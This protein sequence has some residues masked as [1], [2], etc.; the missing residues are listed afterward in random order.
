[1]SIRIRVESFTNSRLSEEIAKKK[2]LQLEEHLKTIPQE[3]LPGSDLE[4]F[5]LSCLKEFKID[6]ENDMHKKFANACINKGLEECLKEFEDE[7]RADIRFKM[8]SAKD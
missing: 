8:T 7:I 6:N 2:L 5:I 3:L 1:M 4:T